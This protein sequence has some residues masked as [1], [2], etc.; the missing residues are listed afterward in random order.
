[1]HNWL[2]SVKLLK[3]ADFHRAQSEHSGGKGA[4]SHTLLITKLLSMTAIPLSSKKSIAGKEGLLWTY[5]S[6]PE[7]FCLS[8][9]HTL[10]EN[11]N[12]V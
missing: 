9:H 5:F 3:T 1:M 2:T 10:Q 11:F 6:T 7:A 12:A 4:Q 8:S